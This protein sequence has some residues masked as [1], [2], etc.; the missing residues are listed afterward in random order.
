MH[1]SSKASI[2]FCSF[3][4]IIPRKFRFQKDLIQNYGKKTVVDIYTTFLEFK[5]IKT[6]LTFITFYN[7]IKASFPKKKIFFEFNMI[8]TNQKQYIIY[9]KTGLI[10][11]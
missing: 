6:F 1:F 5:Y 9:Y 11:F 3:S 2:I 8:D 7:L 10:E 4:V